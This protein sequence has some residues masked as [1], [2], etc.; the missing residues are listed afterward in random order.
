MK[1]IRILRILSLALTLALLATV[2]PA[3]PTLAQVDLRVYPETG[4][5]GDN[6][7]VYGSGFA[8]GAILRFFFSDETA[9]SGDRIDVHVINYEYLGGDTA[10]TE[11]FFQ[12]FYF[13]V[14]NR[15]TDGDDI[16]N[17]HGGTYYVYVTDYSRNILDRV[18]F[19]VLTVGEITINPAEGTVGAGVTVSGTGFRTNQAMTITFADGAV[20]TNPASVT[21]DSNGSFSATFTVPESY[22]GSHTVKAEDESNNSDTAAFT[23][24][25][26]ITMTPASGAAGDTITINGTGFAASTSVTISFG[27]AGVGTSQTNSVG[28]FTATF[29]APAGGAGT[30][31]VEAVDGSGNSATAAFTMAAA[32]VSLSTNAGYVGTEVTVTGTGFIAS[33]PITITFSKNGD[34]ENVAIATSDANGS[35]STG[36]TV[37]ERAA[38]TYKVKVSDGTSTKET[39]F[40]ISIYTNASISPLTSAAAPGHVGTGLTVTGVGFVAGRTVTVTYDGIQVAT[41]T[42]L[43]NRTFSATFN[44]PVSNSGEHSVMATDGTSTKQFSFVMESTPPTTVYPQLPLMDSKLKDGKFD[45]RGDASDP[46]KE[47]SDDSLPI[48]YTL[49]IATE[50]DFSEN[51][52]VLEKIGLTQSEY[53]ITEEEKLESVSK[54]APYYWRVR[55]IDG[56]SNES[57]WSGIGSFYVGSVWALS[58]RTI[59]VIIGIGALLLA[60]FGFWLGR[61]TAYY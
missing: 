25:Q 30:H 53:T 21:T 51:S 10:S 24:R 5:I 19:T 12:G 41:A 35:F 61:K 44:V 58:Q 1:Y 55:A 26:S 38:G 47:V 52:I 27:G 11:G 23:T 4:E 54:D 13:D 7:E 18:E 57:Q 9:Y 59:Y 42:V 46:S 17:V 31:N 49:Q 50:E 39:S 37:P 40:S 48:T 34:T 29:T 15:L 36:F 14:P 8:Q 6:I 43:A 28:S 45:W 22:Q 33:Q 20:T 3:T 16:E 60:V 32:G 56:A 2:V